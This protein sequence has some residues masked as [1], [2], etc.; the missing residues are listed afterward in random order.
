MDVNVLISNLVAIFV[1][2]LTTAATMR[3]KHRFCDH[4][5]RMP[6][7]Y[8]V[9]LRRI[10]ITNSISWIILVSWGQAQL[11]ALVAVDIIVGIPMERWLMRT[12]HKDECAPYHVP[13]QPA[14][15]AR[16]RRLKISILVLILVRCTCAAFANTVMFPYDEHDIVSRALI[17]PLSYAIYRTLMLDLTRQQARIVTTVELPTNDFVIT[18]EEDG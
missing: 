2:C 1:L 10:W 17:M 16:A 12:I 11:D 6:V 5:R 3:V 7:L 8:A 13:G 9:D 14:A 18:D 4:F 15:L